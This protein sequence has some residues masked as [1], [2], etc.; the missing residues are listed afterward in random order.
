L[1][2]SNAFSAAEKNEN[3]LLEMSPIHS[4]DIRV[5]LRHNLSSILSRPNLLFSLNNPAIIN[6]LEESE[7]PVI[8][9]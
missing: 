6:I 5:V 8:G 9:H 3:S 7:R 4:R 1:C 2:P